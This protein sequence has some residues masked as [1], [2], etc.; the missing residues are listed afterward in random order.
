M[1]LLM[2]EDG[3]MTE[4]QGTARRDRLTRRVFV[5]AALVTAAIVSFPWPRKAAPLIAVS[6]RKALP[7]VELQQLDG[8]VWRS[9]EHVGDVVLINYWATWCG[10]CRTET[11]GLARL[12]AD[13]K[14]VAV[15]GI[16]M[17]HGDRAP[18]RSFIKQMQVGYPIAFPEPLSQEAEAMVG[19]PTTI[20]VDKAG[21]VAKTYIGETREAEFRADVGKLLAE[22]D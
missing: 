15:V 3:R 13:T 21:R 17:D 14:G 18:V 10:P 4:V 20:L 6:E 12:A 7:A 8:G 9:K 5:G 11:P 16:S 2:W 19:L 22:R 1:R